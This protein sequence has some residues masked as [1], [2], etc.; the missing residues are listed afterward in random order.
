YLSGTLFAVGWW[1]FFD[2]VA[3]S[4]SHGLPVPIR[5]EDWL[6]GVFSTLSL[7]LVNLI[8]KDHINATEFTYGDDHV[9]TKARACAFLGA[10]MA[11][12]SLGG[13]I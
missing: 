13:S 5:P 11:L 6:P 7:I 9:A 3:F 2:G 4:A 8:S 1:L 10:V 12:S